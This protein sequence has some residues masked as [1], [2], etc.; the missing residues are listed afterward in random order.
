M[1]MVIVNFPSE[2]MKMAASYDENVSEDS[3]GYS[4]K[5]WKYEKKWEI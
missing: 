5:K 4:H 1:R 3:L 2:T